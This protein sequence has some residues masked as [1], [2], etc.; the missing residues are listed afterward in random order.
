MSLRALARLV[1]TAPRLNEHG[2]LVKTLDRALMQRGVK[3]NDGR[4]NTWT[5]WLGIKLEITDNDVTGNGKDVSVSV[6]PHDG[7]PEHPTKAR[8]TAT[9]ALAAFKSALSDL[10]MDLTL[11]VENE[12][13]SPEMKAARLS[14]R[15]LMH[16]I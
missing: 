1:H 5:L 7:L 6:I 4:T 16:E 15:K 3:S 13:A 14:V 2:L 8:G 11:K 9:K 10:Y 12:T